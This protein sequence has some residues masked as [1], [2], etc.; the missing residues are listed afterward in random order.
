MG[1]MS[2]DL[3]SELT[4]FNLVIRLRKAKQLAFLFFGL[5]GLSRCSCGPREPRQF[6]FFHCEACPN[7]QKL[8]F[9]AASALE[10]KHDHEKGY[11][12]AHD[13]QVWSFSFWLSG[14]VKH[15]VHLIRWNLKAVLC[16]LGQDFTTVPA[17][18]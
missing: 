7:Y 15:I 11:R 8:C 17:R 5:L 18:E 6:R 3:T 1:S 4:H 14:E 13:F 10:V 9:T 12:Q 16:Q 2:T